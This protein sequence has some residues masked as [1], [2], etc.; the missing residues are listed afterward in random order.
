VSGMPNNLQDTNAALREVVTKAVD[1][2]VYLYNDYWF[3][4]EP[5]SVYLANAMIVDGVPREKVPNPRLILDLFF[6]V[7]EELRARLPSIGEPILHVEPIPDDAFT[8]AMQD[9]FPNQTQT[10]LHCNSFVLVAGEWIWNIGER[11]VPSLSPKEEDYYRKDDE[12]FG[13]A[14]GRWAKDLP[15]TR[16]LIQGFFDISN[17]F[18]Q[19][20]EASVLRKR[21]YGSAEEFLSSQGG[22]PAQ[23]LIKR[24]VAVKN[25]LEQAKKAFELECFIES[26]ILCECLISRILNEAIE[27]QGGETSDKLLYLLKEFESL[28]AETE[29]DKLVL[30]EMHFW[31]KRRNQATHNYVTRLASEGEPAID[32]LREQT[33]LTAERGIEIAEWFLLWR[34]QWALSHISLKI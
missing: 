4:P 15:L 7:H 33:R 31:R 1:T 30:N 20:I 26:T 9:H 22:K 6:E 21:G 8:E 12:P 10:Y 16:K 19:A 5:F 23:E 11:L 24:G 27:A 13:I 3:M 28:Y 32:S 2:F 14:W 29:D 34:A 17:D 18:M 25:A